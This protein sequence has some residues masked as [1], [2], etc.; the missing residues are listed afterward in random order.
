MTT[1]ASDL[2]K[3][4]G[5]PRLERP[6]LRSLGVHWIIQGDDNQNAFI[7]LVYRKLGSSPWRTGARLF[8]VERR[9][10]LMEHGDSEL[11]VP[12]D[13]WLFAGSALLLEPG[14][15]YELRL[16]LEDPDG[17]KATRTLRA[18]TRSE[19]LVSATAHPPRRAWHG[20]R[21]GNRA[22][23]LPGPGSTRKRPRLP[24]T[25][26]WWEPGS[27]REPGRSTTAA[28]PASRSSG[29]ARAR[30]RP[31]STPRGTQT[32]APARESPRPAV[33]TS[34]SKT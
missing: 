30:A 20:R 26:S 3:P 6:T 14:A 4:L 16:T 10:H 13:G 27:T 2:S 21:H 5:E 29:A 31:S 1:T 15:A 17:G 33:T 11:Q 25:S 18:S 34:G 9:A 22:R 23:S 12:D 24:A 19:P 28:R 7:G 32:R 8:R